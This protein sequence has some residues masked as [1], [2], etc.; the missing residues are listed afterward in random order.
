MDLETAK[1]RI[2]ELRREIEAHDRRYFQESAPL[3]PDQDYD[4]LKAELIELE[5][6]FPTLARE[7]S[8]SR[9]VGDDRLPGFLTYRHRLPMQS[10]ANTYSE[11]EMRAFHQRLVRVSEQEDLQYVVEPK[12]DGVAVSLTYEDGRLVRA[13]TRGNGTEGDDVTENVRGIRTLPS[14]LNAETPPTVI[15][16]RGEIYMTTLEFQRINR[17]REEAGQ[18]VYANPR[19]LT[20]GTIKLLDRGEVAK[21]HLDIVLY[22]LGYAEDLAVETQEGFHRL[23]RD[24]GLP[25]VEKIWTVDGI[26]AVWV[27]IQ[28]LDAMRSDFAYATDGAVVKLNSIAAQQELGATAKAPRWAIAYKFAAERAET[29][30]RGIS[31]QVGRTGVLTPVAELEPVHLAGTT[32]SRATLHNAQELARKDVRVGD[33]VLVEKAGE[34]IPA[35]IEV[36]LAL[37]PP[38]AVSF[39]FPTECPVCGTPTIQFED[40][41]ARRCPNPECPAQVRR[42]VGHFASKSSLDIDGLGEA[43]VDQLVSR[44]LVTRLSDLYRLTRDDLLGLDKFAEKSADN[45]M[46][47]IDVSK[48]ADLRRVIHGLGIPNVGAATAGDLARAFPSLDQLL[49]ATQE[50]LVAVEGIGEKSAE[51]VRAWFADESNRA[52]LD[53]MKELGLAPT[54]PEVTSEG[55]GVLEGK[56]LVLTGTLPSMTRSE[57]RALIEAA[58]GKV[59]GGVS[60]KTDY[61]LAGDEAGSKLTKA[62]KLGVAV[63]DEAG[64]KAMLESTRSD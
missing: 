34:I 1:P 59:T 52:L 14:T 8:P 26:D 54:A 56:V 4:R 9:R 3:I 33:T 48:T 41:V 40:E 60:K 23:L 61:V 29:V 6:A 62:E 39:A 44:G 36:N 57:A 16:I 43:V 64:L 13:V 25:T 11:E 35:V 49:A 15:E 24:W 5:T 18:E 10:L 2:E 55:S 27:A 17:L 63:I 22:G 20:S 38:G 28:E 19:N 32:V 7:D 42:R 21:R 31:I 46:A 30:L 47:A 50:A 45:L 58:G 37:R 12:I 51:A 53:E